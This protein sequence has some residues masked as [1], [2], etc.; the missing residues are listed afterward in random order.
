MLNI[1]VVNAMFI[2]TKSPL[3]DKDK[4]KRYFKNGMLVIF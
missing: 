4:K 3:I 1:C 2:M